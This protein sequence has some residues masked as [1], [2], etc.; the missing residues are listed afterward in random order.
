MNKAFIVLCML[1]GHF[2]AD[3]CL[4]GWLASAKQKSYW[5]KNNPQ[6]LY[7]YDYMCALFMH[8]FSWSFMIM[9]PIAY[10]ISFNIDIYFITFVIV[11]TILHV[12]IDD[13]KANEGTINLWGDQI[14]HMVQIFITAF[15][16][17]R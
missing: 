8:S 17:L 12:R 11:N 9:L 7:K 6:E 16:Y 13:W 15:A 14:L 1:F 4:Q 2:V 3:Y 10:F 5:E